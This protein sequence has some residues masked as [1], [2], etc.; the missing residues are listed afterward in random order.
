M[1]RG[2]QMFK[3]I[4]VPLDGSQLAESVI[5]A[6]RSLGRKFD[7]HIL[8]FHVIEK[9][10]PEAVHG[11]PH[12]SGKKEAEDYLR[13]FA[14]QFEKEGLGA[15]F[16][17]H[18]EDYAGVDR[19]IT[20]HVKEMKSDLIIMCSHGRSGLYDMFF[21]NIAQKVLSASR[22]PLL[23]IQPDSEKPQKEFHC[24]RILIPMDE[25]P[26]HYHGL[27]KLN[28]LLQ[29]CNSEIILARV[30]PT[31]SS[32]P[33]KWRP[34]G[35]LLPSTSQELLEIEAD[36]AGKQLLRE[37]DRI[38]FEGVKKKGVVVRGRPVDLIPEIAEEHQADILV[39]STHGKFGFDALLSGSFAAQ[40]CR[41]CTLPIFFLRSR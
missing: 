18:S 21:G 29:K 4:F 24:H 5:P 12:I 14:D 34:S 6:V 37:A 33:G 7:A 10:P 25:N 20:E 39:L 41:N 26:S 19:S 38:F 15:D 9:N 23:M 11:E 1:S 28:P 32:I 36:E 8:F 2:I 3:N 40:V 17:V 30:I 31:L 35:K 27:S 16:H 22:I 13:K